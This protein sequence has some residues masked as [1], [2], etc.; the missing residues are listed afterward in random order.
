MPPALIWV[1]AA[2]PL[3]DYDVPDNFPG[4]SQR[5][6]DLIEA[7]EP[8]GHHVF[9]LAVHDEDYQWIADRWL[10]VIC[11]LIDSVDRTLTNLDFRNQAMWDRDSVPNPRL[12]FNAAQVGS[13]HF[14]RD[15]YLM[16]GNQQCSDL[17]AHMI[18]EQKLIAIELVNRETV[19]WL[20]TAPPIG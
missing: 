15:R 2:E 12:V 5:L 1:D 19:S 13:C 4:V 17:A 6:H 3:G 16:P 18:S 14:W 7:L 11:N 20:S 8:G 9:P 10:W